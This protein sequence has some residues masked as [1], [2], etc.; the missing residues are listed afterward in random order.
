MPNNNRPLRLTLIIRKNFEIGTA[1]KLV[2]EFPDEFN[3]FGF[4]RKALALTP[5]AMFGSA[6][7]LR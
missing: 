5:V 2:R 7:A 3:Q 6:A 1:M 4:N